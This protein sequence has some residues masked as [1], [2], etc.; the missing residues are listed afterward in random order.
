M[1]TVKFRVSTQ[2]ESVASS[3]NPVKNAFEIMMSNQRELCRPRLPER[4]IEKNKKDKLFNDLID[5]LDS[6]GLKWPERDKFWKMFLDY[7]HISLVVY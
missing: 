3:V 7:T 4:L 5:L 6:K 2:S 1:E